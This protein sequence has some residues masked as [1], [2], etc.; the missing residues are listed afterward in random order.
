M[1]PLIATIDPSD[2][3]VFG[4]MN[5]KTTAAK[6]PGGQR[7]L[8]LAPPSLASHADALASV[9]TRYD[10]TITDL[11]M[12]DR[13][14]AGLVRLPSAQYD[15]ILVLS[16]AAATLTESLGLLSRAVVG[17]IADSLKPKGQLRAEQAA[18]NLE[19]TALA[20]EAV[21]AGLVGSGGGFSK[22]DY[23]DND[24]AVSLKLGFRK[25][26]AAAPAVLAPTPAPAPAVGSTVLN[27]HT[28][29]AK[30]AVPA[31]VGFDFGDDL[32]DDL[33]DEETLMTEEDLKRPINI[34]MLPP[35]SI[36]TPLPPTSLLLANKHPQPSSA[37][38]SPAS[39][40]V[41]ARTARAASPSA[42]RPRTP[43][44]APRPTRRSP[45]SSSPPTT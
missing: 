35:W 31:G 27:G 20:K 42:S 9:L 26:K 4:G 15:L 29:G 30:P 33:I 16:D 10:R 17:A 36:M 44:S 8:L 38:P 45:A 18:E 3:V 19:T 37:S 21:L 41:P 43:P 32:D 34:R 40:A 11:Q 6:P 1:A 7:A 5:T 22:P 12:L 23:G 25:K 2:D 39:D 13:L 14:A 28:N 24:G